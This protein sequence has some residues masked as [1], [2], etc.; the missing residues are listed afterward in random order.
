MPH[1]YLKWL[2]AF[3][4]NQSEHV[5]GKTFP[6][7]RGVKQGHVISPMLFNEAWN[8]PCTNGNLVCRILE[9]ILETAKF[10]KCKVGRRLDAKGKELKQIH[11]DDGGTSSRTICCGIAFVANSVRRPRLHLRKTLGQHFVPKWHILIASE[12]GNFP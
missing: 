2:A 6:I 7:Q 9:L 10:D 11:H 3:Y 8:M 4:C 12:S 1:S 5:N